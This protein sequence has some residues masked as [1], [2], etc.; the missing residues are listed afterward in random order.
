MDD[1]ERSPLIENYQNMQQSM[2]D[3]CKEEVKRVRKFEGGS[4]GGNILFLDIGM[5][6]WESKQEINAKDS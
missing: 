1:S 5:K 6:N 4:T 2:I 3:M